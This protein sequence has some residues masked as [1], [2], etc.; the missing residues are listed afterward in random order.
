MNT[1][2]GTSFKALAQFWLAL[3]DMI[4]HYLIVAVQIFTDIALI[5]L[6]H[7]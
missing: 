2:I 7:H 4:M 6:E 1:I 3:Q 5:V